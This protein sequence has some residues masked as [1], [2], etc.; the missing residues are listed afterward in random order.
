GIGASSMIDKTRNT[1]IFENGLCI[2]GMSILSEDYLHI[3]RI[4]TAFLLTAKFRSP[5]CLY[6]RYP[7]ELSL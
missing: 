1:H 2:R 4:K 6:R 5:A 3:K 7:L